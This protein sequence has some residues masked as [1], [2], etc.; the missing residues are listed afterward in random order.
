MIRQEYLRFLQTLKGDNVSTAMCKVANLVLEN[1]DVLRP[2]TTN[3]GQRIKK[4]V[5]IAQEQWQDL[6]VDIYAE[7]NDVHDGAALFNQLASLQVGPFRGFSRSENFDLH[8]PLV[9]IYG[10]NGTG[11]TSFCEALEFG[12]LGS[13]V[14]AECKRIS[15]QDYLKNAF[16]NRYVP[17]VIEVIDDQGEIHPVCPNETKNRFCFVEKN[18]IDSFSRIAAQLP[19]KQS[20]LI[21]TLFGLD[22]FT[23]FVRNFTAEIDERYIDLVGSK[24]QQLVQKQQSLAAAHQRINENT[25]ALS[26]LNQEEVELANQ[27]KP[28]ISF[29]ELL[30]ALGTPEAPGEIAVLEAE[31]QQP[32][33]IKSGLTFA[34]LLSQKQIIENQQTNLAAKDQELTASS[35][36]LSFK[37]LYSA[38]SDLGSISRDECPACKTP[39]TSTNLNPFELA[40]RELAKLA[41]LSQL[42]QERDQLRTDLSNSIGSVHQMA[43]TACDRFSDNPLQLFLHQNESQTDVNWWGLFQ[44]I[45]DD[46]FSAWQHL[47]AQVQKLE[48]MDSDLEQ[49]HQLRENKQLRLTQLR[50]FDRQATILN[51]RRTTLIDELEQARA[52]IA[53]FNEANAT[54]IAEAEAEKPV[55]VRNYEISNAYTTFVEWLIHYKD[56]LPGKLIADLGEKVTQLYNAFNRNDPPKDLLASIKLPLAQGQRIE[57][58]F[59]GNP[60]GWFDALHVLSEGH[61]R[62]LGLAILMAKNIKENCPVLI[63]DDPVNAIDDDHRESIRRTLFED[64]F[65]T[66]K[67]IVLTCHGE[68]F[69]KDIHSLLGSERSAKSKNFIFLPRLDDQ[70]IRIDFN[71]V[72]RNY[73]LAA[74]EHIERLEVREALSKARQ[75]LEALTKDKLWRYVN[76]YG[77]G[78]LSIKLRSAKAPIELRNLTEQLK[79]KIE[80]ADFSHDN[81]ELVATPLEILLGESGESREW[82]YL[83]RG[84]HEENDRTEFDRSVV[85]SIIQ[86]LAQIDSA[87]SQI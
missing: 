80:K 71:C 46:G 26:K 51:A 4:L 59:Q 54:L 34:A 38:V 31:I 10:P 76:T 56:S 41:H 63:F 45:G 47:Q 32:L 18:R 36:A 42:E 57:V 75:A 58:A 19:A 53:A 67:Q 11:K 2:L 33:V 15:P 9:L 14:E 60:E 81:K 13:V 86:S 8:S 66:S 48:Q 1:L 61:I 29:T 23:D 55:V 65:F 64:D 22:S 78:N 24:N 73:I 20:E 85:A 37:Q 87:L 27:Y 28:D 68:E 17:P 39:L 7:A 84:T 52:V 74:Q 40:T 30:E 44:N 83:N 50:D 35:T 72:P 77:D 12:L 5:E 82:R 49:A 3:Q 79:S 43:K 6:R 21:S 16:I 25:E 69:F 62:C 70:H